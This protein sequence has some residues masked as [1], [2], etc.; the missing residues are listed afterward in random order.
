MPFGGGEG[1]RIGRRSGSGT[2]LPIGY[3]WVYQWNSSTEMSHLGL[4][5]YPLRLLDNHSALSST[6]G[7]FLLQEENGYLSV[8][9]SEVHACFPRCNLPTA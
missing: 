7:V 5:E 3:R 6:A 1:W 8:H 9:I 4:N 2:S